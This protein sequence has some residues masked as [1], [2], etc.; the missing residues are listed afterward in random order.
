[1]GQTHSRLNSNLKIGQIYYIQ[2]ILTSVKLISVNNRNRTGNFIYLPEIKYNTNPA[3]SVVHNQSFDWLNEHLTSVDQQMNSV[4]ILRES[5]IM[6]DILYNN[7]WT[8]GTIIWIELEKMYVFDNS[9]LDII[10]I[11]PKDCHNVAKLGTHTT[12]NLDDNPHL[13]SIM[14]DI[15][16]AYEKSNVFNCG[17]TACQECSKKLSPKICH[18]CRTPIISINKFEL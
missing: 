12:N 7:K 1:M 11:S 13:P 15:C 18:I 14:C 3:I 16:Y 6:I 17:H 8:I 10:V 9:S 4:D 2:S 5:G